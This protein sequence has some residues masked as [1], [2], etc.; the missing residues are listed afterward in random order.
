VLALA[1][2]FPA[3]QVN[4]INRPTILSYQ[5]GL[6]QVAREKFAKIPDTIL[7]KAVELND[8]LGRHIPGYSLPGRLACE[9]VL[10]DSMCGRPEFVLLS[11]PNGQLAYVGDAVLTLS[12]CARSYYAQR[13]RNDHQ[14]LRSRV[15]CTEA[16]AA[17][18]D[19]LFPAGIPLV[20]WDSVAQPGRNPSTRQKAT[21]LE[22]ILGAM[23]LDEFQATEERSAEE[24]IKAGL[25]LD[26]IATMTNLVWTNVKPSHD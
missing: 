9:V 21:F 22:A 6:K 24:R 12:L 18:A 15:T 20:T 14:A 3:T 17:A 11:K 23:E 19:A 16:F 25:V 5:H 8:Q 2:Q 10:D 7:V 13:S 4:V 1:M 26:K